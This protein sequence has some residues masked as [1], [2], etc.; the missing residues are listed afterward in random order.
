MIKVRF[1]VPYANRDVGDVIEFSD[2]M[3]AHMLY[4]KG[5]VEIVS[6]G[7]NNAD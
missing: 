7:T 2:C 6:V 4:Q 5:I 3:F 1:L